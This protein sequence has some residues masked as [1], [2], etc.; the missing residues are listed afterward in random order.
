MNWNEYRTKT[1]GLVYG[2]C[3]LE[4]DAEKINR[5]TRE[6]E[7]FKTE[8]KRLNKVCDTAKALNK[9]ILAAIENND[10]E[11]AY[12]LSQLLAEVID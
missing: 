12:I 8:T 10:R 2:I 1:E 11:T 3:D 7:H 4:T 5:L 9:S 6:R